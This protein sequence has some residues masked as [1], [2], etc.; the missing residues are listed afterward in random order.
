MKFNFC[1]LIFSVLLGSILS[2]SSAAPT[3]PRVLEEKLSKPD[4]AITTWIGDLQVMHCDEKKEG[5]RKCKT[6]SMPEKVG[7]V[8]KILV[9]DFISTTKASWLV[10]SDKR[11]SLCSISINS[12]KI[13]CIFIKSNLPPTVDVGYMSVGQG[14][15]TL[16][17]KSSDTKN[18]PSTRK[19][20]SVVDHFTKSLDEAAKELQIKLNL[21]HTK[22]T[23]KPK[24]KSPLPHAM[25][26]AREGEEIDEECDNCDGGDEGGGG[27][28]GDGGGD[29]GGDNGGYNG[30][31][32][33]PDPSDYDEVS[34][35]GNGTN[36]VYGPITV[37]TIVAPRPDPTL[38]A[39]STAWS[40]CSLFGLFCSD[41][42]S[43]P[44]MPPSAN[45]TE[46]RRQVCDADYE[47]DMKECSAYYGAFGSATW[48]TCKGI[49]AVRYAA[50]LRSAEGK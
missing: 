13:Y 28:S 19:M 27:S 37:C 50:C 34:D 20:R 48:A 32:N 49:A 10:F 24:S 36:C 47:F 40:F 11:P 38:P 5:K 39:P 35:A 6:I 42:T 45:T 4:A 1:R 16:T 31:Y 41:P 22:H 7:E 9:G 17:Y 46:E 25:S 3:Q 12:K 23:S 33:S 44:N 26:L 18:P 29:G 8:N 2:I 30:D 14:L 21:A 43:I 15:N